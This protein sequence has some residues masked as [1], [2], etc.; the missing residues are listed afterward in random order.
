M[1]ELLSLHHIT[2]P[3]RYN[4]IKLFNGDG[5]KLDDNV[6]QEIETQLYWARR[7]SAPM[8]HRS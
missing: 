5:Y 4:G 1:Q 7:K 3:F 2:F 6:E 8:I